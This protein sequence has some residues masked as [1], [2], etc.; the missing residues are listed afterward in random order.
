MKFPLTAILLAAVLVGALSAPSSAG[1]GKW[2]VRYPE[3][4]FLEDPIFD[5][6]VKSSTG[7][8]QTVGSNVEAE[9]SEQE[10]ASAPPKKPAGPDLS[11]SWQIALQ[12]MANRSLELILIQSADRLQG[13]G[14]L[15]QDG[16]KIATTATGAVSEGKVKLDVKLVVDGKLNQASQQYKLDLSIG[17]DGM[18]GIYEAFEN[19]RLAG[20]GNATAI[21]AAA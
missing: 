13:Y 16:K 2:V 4:D 9:Q 15:S 1:C 14:S 11:G 19:D 7:A 6:A 12:E 17:E 5:E 8:S 20:R 21:R 3:T 10:V 18:T